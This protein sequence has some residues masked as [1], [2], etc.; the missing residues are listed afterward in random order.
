MSGHWKSSQGGG[1]GGERGLG[2]AGRREAGG[3]AHRAPVTPALPAQEACGSQA[4]AAGT[5]DT[6]AGAGPPGLQGQAPGARRPGLP[7]RE[8]PS[9]RGPP[10]ERGGKGRQGRKKFAAGRGV[11]LS[12]PAVG[13]SPGE[14][15][16][17]RAG[18]PGLHPPARPPARVVYIP[19]VSFKPGAEAGSR[20]SPAAP[21]QS[22]VK[23]CWRT[24]AGKTAAPRPRPRCSGAGSLPSAPRPL[25]ARLASWT[26]VPGEGATRARCPRPRRRG[27][28]PHCFLPSPDARNAK[29]ASRARPPPQLQPRPGPPTSARAGLPL[30]RGRRRRRRR[31]RKEH[32]E[33]T[34]VFATRAHTRTSS[35]WAA[36]LAGA[37]P[38]RLWP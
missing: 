26:D 28:A 37:A 13:L 17:T 23:I 38:S 10:E 24:M 11:G 34:F 16:G 8:R 12:G 36:L 27:R 19:G 25:L 9:L 20:P 7:P 21:G 2:A 1:E 33:I 4:G 31:G 3:Q 32:G 22:P 14:G 35:P 6:Q 29:Q 18:C 15:W 5:P 30:P